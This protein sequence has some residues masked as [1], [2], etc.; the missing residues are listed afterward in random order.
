[1][2][3]MRSSLHMF[4]IADTLGEFRQ[5]NQRGKEKAGQMTPKS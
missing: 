2:K 4:P 5:R 3:D 1:V